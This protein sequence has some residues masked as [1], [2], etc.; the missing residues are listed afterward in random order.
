MLGSG[1]VFYL[2]RSRRENQTPDERGTFTQDVFRATDVPRDNAVARDVFYLLIYFLFFFRDRR[3]AER[4]Q[5]SRL[6]NV[7]IENDKL[8]GG[9][10]ACV[11]QGILANQIEKR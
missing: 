8:V 5:S 3:K 11:W 9:S 4:I 7:R 6:L 10:S 2:R 1:G